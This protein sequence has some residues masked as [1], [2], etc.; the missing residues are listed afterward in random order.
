LGKRLQQEYQRLSAEDQ[1][2]FHKWL[3]ANAIFGAILF[4]G[5]LAMAWKG[6]SVGR[7]DA[8]IAAHSKSSNIAVNQT[9][10]HSTK[11]KK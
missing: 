5:M 1:R 11:S 7:T 8:A 9:V 3:K 6:N 2:T 10:E 4:I